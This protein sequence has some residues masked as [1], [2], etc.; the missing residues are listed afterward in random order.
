[1]HIYIAA[2]VFLESL[3]FPCLEDDLQILWYI[4]AEPLTCIS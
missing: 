1:M 4:T 3:S 2:Y